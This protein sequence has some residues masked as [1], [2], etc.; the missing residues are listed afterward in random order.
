MNSGK[1]LATVRLQPL[2]KHITIP[3]G[4]TILEATRSAGIQLTS[5]CGGEANCGQCRVIVPSG[6]VSPLNEDEIFLLSKED[7]RN[8]YRLACCTRILSNIVVHIP[9]ESLE[10]EQRLQIES[11]L[12]TIPPQPFIRAIPLQLSPPTLED[13]RADFSRLRQELEGKVNLSNLTAPLGVL[14]NLPQ[15]LRQTKWRPTVFLRQ[16][17]VIGL[18]PMDSRPLGLAVDLGTTKIAATL[19]DLESG[20][21]IATAGA[22]NPQISYGE[23]V[24][25]RLNYVHKN[26]AGGEQLSKLARKAIN[27]LS[28]ELVQ[29]AN[30]RPE[31]IA[32]ACIVGNTAMLHLLLQLPV[33][34]LALSPYV[35]A[36]CDALDIPAPELELPIAAGAKVHIPP[37]IGGY[38]GADHVAMVLA[39]DLDQ[40]PKISLG[41]DIGTNTEISLRTPGIPFL[42]AVSCASGPAF[43]G[44]HIRHGMRAASGAIEKVRIDSHGI[45][46][47]TVN[48]EPPIGICGSGI[49]DAIAALYQ[50]GILDKNGRFQPQ[51]QNVREGENGLEF[52]LV[53]AHQSG[54]GREITLSQKDVNE[55]Q[56]AKG[57]IQAGMQI[58]LESTQTPPESVE[59]V[60]IA[61]AFGSYINIESA[62]AIGLFP[63]LPNAKFRQVGN[64]AATGAKWMLISRSAR[65]RAQEIARRTRYLE[66]TSF[67]KFNRTFALS[68][69]FPPLTN[70]IAGALS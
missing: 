19:V 23:D 21:D 65:Q 49:L 52:L 27:D 31:Q 51:H 14:Q 10:S 55:I 67:P 38:V 53:P 26:T 43:E 62:Q 25:S 54:S 11:N 28:A 9:K 50:Q 70:P 20:E 61:G 60:I 15:Q 5:A 1:T 48:H 30:A 6:S 3:I 40:S 13:P 59:E 18:L 33:H 36:V 32:E 39:T 45:S 17:E 37:L 41:I 57:A 69:L 34:Q 47:I 66:L 56:L 44:A 68:M 24:V 58:L 42:T 29:K 63:H 22:P 64:A 35:A 7:Q 8:G 16:A 2:G 4:V 12:R 46:Y